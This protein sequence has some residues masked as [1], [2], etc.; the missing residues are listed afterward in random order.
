MFT[1]LSAVTFPCKYVTNFV[2]NFCMLVL[3]ADQLLRLLGC[4]VVQTCLFKV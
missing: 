1:L 3:N 2:L 4:N